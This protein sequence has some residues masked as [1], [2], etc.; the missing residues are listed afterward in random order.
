MSVNLEG[1]RVTKIDSTKNRKTGRLAAKKHK[2]HKKAEYKSKVKK[3]I[4]KATELFL[5]HSSFVLLVLFCGQS[6][7]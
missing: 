4:T 1:M 2:L 3:G 6:T 5:S 7:S